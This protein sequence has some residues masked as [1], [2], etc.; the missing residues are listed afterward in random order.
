MID[1]HS[2]ILPGLDDG[3]ADIEGSVALARAASESGTRVMVATPHIREDHPFPLEA[4]GD[5]TERL[6]RIL[7]QEGVDLRVVPG[8]EVALTK[9]GELD[10][11]TLQSLCLG[12]GRYLLVE[13]PYTYAPELVER[14]L[15][16]L[17]TRGYRPILAHP[18]RSPSFLSDFVRLSRLV[19]RGM[20]CSIT[21]LSMVG[22][23]GGT[24]QA[25]TT[26]L[27]AAGLVHNVA[28]D[29]HDQRGRPPGLG[30]GFERLDA[31]LPGLAE[32]ADWFTR[33]APQAILAGQPLPSRPEPPRH[34]ERG[35]RRLIPAP[36]RTA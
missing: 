31:R 20:H 33:D 3:P 19:D 11:A 36:I 14:L 35:W 18:E 29:A 16:D 4:I 1:L 7:G 26:R 12:D 22:A 13:S 34:A 10:D 8:G 23:F 15:F 17:Q 28:S 32:Q 5:Q 9:V 27:F 2:H 30:H 24:V 25:F 21:A 6:N